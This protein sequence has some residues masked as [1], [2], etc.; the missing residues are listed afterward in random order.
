MNET[1]LFNGE[2]SDSTYIEWKAI[3]TDKRDEKCTI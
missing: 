2:I 1:N 3:D